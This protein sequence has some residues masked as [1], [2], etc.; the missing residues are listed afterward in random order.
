MLVSVIEHLPSPPVSQAQRMPELIESSP[1]ADFIDTKVKDAMIKFETGPD[2][3]VV[4][5][6]SKMVAIPE[7]ELPRNKRRTGGTMSAEEARELA[8]KK[9][10][11]FA[12]AQAAESGPRDDDVGGLAFALSTTTIEEP[13][14]TPE[15]A[16]EKDDPEHLIGFARLYSG[17]LHVG[18]EVYVLPPK[19]TPANAKAKP[20][21]Q[22]VKVAGLYLLMG[23]G[24]E[25][26]ESVPAGVVFGIEGLAGHVLKSGT[27]CSTLDGGIN[28]AGV[29]L[30]TQPI[31]RV[32]L[33]PENPGDLDKMVRGLKMLEQSDPCAVY[34]VLESGEH[35]LATAGELHLER[36]L[37]DLIERFAK[38][39]LTVGEPIVPYRETII[40]AAEM[41]PPR[42]KDLP[43]GTVVAETSSK[44]VSLR[45]RVRPLPAAVTEF[46]NKNAGAIKRLYAERRATEESKRRKVDA[47]DSSNDQNGDSAVVEEAAV[48]ETGKALSLEEFKTELSA[49]FAEAKGEK[50]VWHD[51]V[52]KIAAFGPRR[53]GPNLLIDATHGETCT[54]L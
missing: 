25:S 5:Y 8:R 46:L 45:I 14:E 41:N 1:G 26:L 18:D 49:A 2:A 10:A 40:R 38:C 30:G 42:D 33:E 36:C 20:V 32:A 43:R 15:E 52:E 28:L 21:P 31:V 16:P 7:S 4:A 19:F 23:R 50:E 44:Q 9:R 24:L 12:S 3:P 47:E 54:R 11:Q 35:V 53:V 13:K 37:K 6:V 34:E 39:E 29:N 27:L 48:V 17:T 51:V 22:K